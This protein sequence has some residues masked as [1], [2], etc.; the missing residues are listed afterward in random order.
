MPMRDQQLLVDPCSNFVAEM[1]RRPS[2]FLKTDK[3][4]TKELKIDEK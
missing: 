1:L 3:L 4:K 2:F